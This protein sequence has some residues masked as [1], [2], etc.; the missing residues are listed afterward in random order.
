MPTPIPRRDALTRLAVLGLPLTGCIS[1]DSDTDSKHRTTRHPNKMTVET[2][3]FGT[4]PDGRDVRR[5]T[6]ANGRGSL[7]HIAEYGG[8]VTEL[9][10]PDRHGRPGNVVLGF[11]TLDRYLKGHPFFGAITGRYANR[12]AAGRFVLDGKSYTLAT[13]N[14]PNHLHGGMV[15]FD[16]RLWKGIPVRTAHSDAAVQFSY[17]SPD[18]EEGYPGTLAASVTYALTARHELRIDYAATTTAPTVINLTNHSYFN[19][20]GSGDIL[21]HELELAADR[22]T[23]VDAGLIP[24]GELA[25]VRG[26]ALDFTSAHR[27]G[28]RINR[29]GLATPGYDHNFVLNHGGGSLGLAARLRDPAS[30][31]IMEVLTTEPAVQCYS[32]IHLDGT[33]TGTG[34]VRYPRFGAVCLE[35]QHYPDSPNKPH[36]PSTVLRPGQVYQTTTIY[37]FSAS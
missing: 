23:P 20:A 4:L 12:I 1:G 32:A 35:T 16:K 25:P 27:M 34:G 21:N 2:S 30:G 6:L 36:F 11:D 3:P 7:A 13:N 15:G 19:L 9:H 14:G 26:T 28:E 17:T 31:R 18:G 5:F 29:A 24:T 10:V 37:R 22:Y 33:I 8:I